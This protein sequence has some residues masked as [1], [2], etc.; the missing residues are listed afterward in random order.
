MD[1][2][3]I[4]ARERCTA[5][6]R[7]DLPDV[8]RPAMRAA[9]DGG[10]RVVEFTL[11]TPN[12]LEHVAHFSQQPGVVVGAGTVM[13]VAD[14]EAAVEAGARFVVSPVTDPEVI[15][16][17]GDHDI[18]SI[19]GTYTPTEMQAAVR[20]GAPICK[21]FP[22]PPDGPGYV[23]FCLGP[24]PSL[25]IFPTAGVT[26]DNAAEFLR[27]GAFGV[28]FV[29]SLFAPDDLRNHA[30]DAIRRRAADMTSAVRSEREAVR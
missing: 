26:L 7:T 27:A 12:A 8:V 11:N 5:I 13:S 21:L 17:C 24:M 23:K 10:F 19:P 22:A 6:L 14:A 2:L 9:I 18:V 1:V 30:F 3:D 20:A 15:G 25:R 28:G 16:W 4:L 29:G